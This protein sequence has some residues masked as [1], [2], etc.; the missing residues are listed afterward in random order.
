[1]MFF[2]LPELITPKMFYFRV[3]QFNR[4]DQMIIHISS[5][6]WRSESVKTRTNK[7][8]FDLFFLFHCT[9]HDDVKQM[10]VRNQVMKKETKMNICTQL[11]L[12]KVQT[13]LF[14]FKFMLYTNR[15]FDSFRLYINRS[16]SNLV[17]LSIKLQKASKRK[18]CC[19]LSG[20]C[21]K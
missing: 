5:Q 6:I 2:I 3:S 18:G 4:K 10:L 17:F 1:M 9:L 19:A 13:R 11:Q 21:K 14:F 20:L 7:S 15:N 8:L 16:K 12:F